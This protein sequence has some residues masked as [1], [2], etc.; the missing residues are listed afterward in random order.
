MI[1][2]KDSKS[3]TKEQVLAIHLRFHAETSEGTL[4]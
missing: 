3:F 1:F 4:K 2:F